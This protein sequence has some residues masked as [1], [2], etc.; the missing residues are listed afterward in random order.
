MRET[1]R[2]T[3]LARA[4]LPALLAGCVAGCAAG[5]SPTL[6]AGDPPQRAPPTTATATPASCHTRGHGLLA[7]PDPRCTPGARSPAVTQSD[8]DSTICVPGYTRT[9][10][11]R[12][13]IT[14]PEKLDSMD[15]YGDT[16]SPHDYEYDH[17]VSLE[18]GGAANDPRNL[19]PEPGR[20]PNPK[21]RL[22]NRLH[23]LVCAGQLRL[24]A[25]QRQIAANW[26]AAYRRLFG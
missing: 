18:L 10:R 4:V 15:A 21:D 22:E 5:S 1:H 20:S 24:S 6:N 13:S 3:R 16:G 12:E 25:A 2:S 9:V 14:E 8:I 17:L 19:W 7:L 23:E 11:P 26:V